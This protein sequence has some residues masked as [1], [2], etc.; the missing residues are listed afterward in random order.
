MIERDCEFDSL[1]KG[2]RCIRCGYTLPRTYAEKPRRNCLVSCR[3]LG[4]D[5][6]P[7]KAECQTCKGERL[8]EVSAAKCS[9]H[10]RCL[11]T[12]APADPA[13]WQ[14]RPESEIYHLCR[15]CES[16]VAELPPAPPAE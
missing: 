11:P 2:S 5:V 15:G 9:A 13:K 12:Y 6:R 16:F 4:E 3:H 14:A 10:G 1:A 7:I 8:V